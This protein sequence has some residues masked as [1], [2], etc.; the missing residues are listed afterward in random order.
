MKYPIDAEKYV[1]TMRLEFG[2]NRAAEEA[3]RAIIPFINDAYVA[4]VRGENGYPLNVDAELQNFADYTG[5]TVEH[6][7]KNRLIPLMLQWANRAYS[8]GAAEAKT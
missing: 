1:A 3:H 2:P 8:Q 6:L 7:R 5:T 4:G